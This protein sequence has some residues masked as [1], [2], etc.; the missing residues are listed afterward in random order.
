VTTP[1][2]FGSQG[3]PPLYPELIDWLATELIRLGWDLKA[4]EKEIV[5]SATYRQSSVIS[6]ELAKR[7]PENRLLARGPRC[8]LSAEEMRDN[9]LAVGGLISLKIGGPS[10]KPYQPAGLWEELAGGA[11]QGPYQ[12]DSGENLHRRSLYTYRKRTVPHPTTSTFDAPTWETCTAKRSRTNTP[13]QALALL[14]DETYVEAARGLAQR[15]IREGGTDL[16]G[17][18]RYGFRLATGRRPGGKEI[19]RLS[20]SYHRYHESFRQ[21]PASAKSLLSVGEF[22]ADSQLDAGEL[23]AFA[24]IGNILLNLDETI[25]NH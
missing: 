16:D 4:L 20:T 11:G 5:M 24:T 15:M 10:V 13:L 18:L 1:D 23:A 14:N 3:E 12:Q 6:A 22:R 25:S 7:D 8:R 9:A 2:N 21:D 17:R 19:E